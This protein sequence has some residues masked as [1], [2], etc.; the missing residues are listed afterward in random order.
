MNPIFKGR[1]ITLAVENATFRPD[2]VFMEHRDRAHR[3]PH[4][5]LH[6]F[7]YVALALVSFWGFEYFSLGQHHF[8]QIEQT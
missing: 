5:F 7:G 2:A 1:S 3:I 8:P 4:V 6:R